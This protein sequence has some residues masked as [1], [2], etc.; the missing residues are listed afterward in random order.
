MQGSLTLFD[1]DSG[2]HKFGQ[3]V[4]F[5]L[6]LVKMVDKWDRNNLCIQNHGLDMMWMMFIALIPYAVKVATMIK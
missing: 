4:S 3:I 5:C 6:K 1:K 2:Y